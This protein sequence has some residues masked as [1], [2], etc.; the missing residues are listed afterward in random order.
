[1]LPSD[2][3]PVARIKPP[4]T[5][6]IPFQDARTSNGTLARITDRISPAL[7]AALPGLLAESPDPDTALL[8]F[9]RLV[10]E[11]A[12]EVRLL[13]RNNFLSNMSVVYFTN[14]GYLT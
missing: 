2:T 7:A 13:Y 9:D 10:S 14:I 6:N 8:F 4:K 3:K 1:M 12:E 5:S 11:S